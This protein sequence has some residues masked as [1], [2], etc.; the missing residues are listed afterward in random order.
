MTSSNRR[1]A[2]VAAAI[3]VALLASWSAGSSGAFDGTG[4]EVIIHSAALEPAVVRAL[5]HERVTFRNQSG[6]IVH[7][8][9]IGANG[10]HHVFQIPGTIWA[11]FHQPGPHP[12]VV[13]FSNGQPPQLAGRVDIEVPSAGGEPRECTDFTVDDVCIAP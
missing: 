5:L 6:R 9:F 1:L 12:Y 13:H 7:I 4:H 3:L 2:I 11:E 10:Q 8:Q